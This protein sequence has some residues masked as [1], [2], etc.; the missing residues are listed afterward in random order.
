MRTFRHSNNQITN[1]DCIALQGAHG[2][3]RLLL[4]QLQMVRLSASAMQYDD[5]KRQAIN[6]KVLP[7]LPLTVAIR[8]NSTTSIYKTTIVPLW[9]LVAAPQRHLHAAT[10]L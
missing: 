7:L 10:A 4:G 5:V 3:L 1:K 2:D 9:V 8:Q 6:A